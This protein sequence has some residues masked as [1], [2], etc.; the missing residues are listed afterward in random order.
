MTFSPCTNSLSQDEAS[1]RGFEDG[2]KG[3][4]LNGGGLGPKAGVQQSTNDGSHSLGAV[5]SLFSAVRIWE[6]NTSTLENRKQEVLLSAVLNRKY[7]SV[8][9][10]SVYLSTV[11]STLSK[12]A[13]RF[14]T[15]YHCHI[16][17]CSP[18]LAAVVAVTAPKQRSFRP[19]LNCVWKTNNAVITV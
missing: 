3:R 7:K 9:V 8:S 15:I 11:T 10:D 13:L 17:H 5:L 16:E 18:K 12:L 6:N 2:N 1:E 14:I 19:I 4:L